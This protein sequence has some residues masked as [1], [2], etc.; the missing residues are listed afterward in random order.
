MSL[1]K[2]KSTFQEWKDNPATQDFL[3]FLAERQTALAE[4]WARGA[5][6]TLEQQAQSVLLGHLSQI[7]FEDI[8]EH[9]G[10]EGPT[11]EQ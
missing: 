6:M 10:M 8:C 2:D 3:T 11:N 1:M 9:Y 4:A 5:S 7:S